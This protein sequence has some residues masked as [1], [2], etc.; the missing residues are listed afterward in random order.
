VKPLTGAPSRRAQST[1]SNVIPLR[2]CETD[3][4]GCPAVKLCLPSG[5]AADELRTFA[6]QID[7]RRHL[8]DGE[9]LYRAG[10]PFQALYAVHKGSIKTSLLSEDGR[11]Q[12]AGYYLQGEIV[13]FD[14]IASASHTCRASALEDAK[15]CAIPFDRLE[16]LARAIPALQLGIY[17]MLAREVR[18]NHD[19]MLLFGIRDAQVRLVSLLLEL[20]ER[21]RGRGVFGSELALHLSRAE[22]GSYLGLSLAT[23]SRALSR[24]HAAGLMQVQ[25]RRIKLL[26]PP[27]LKRLVGGDNPISPA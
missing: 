12:V 4:P 8:Q 27:S 22:M 5:L 6:Q 15:V 24:L 9:V 16:E 10:D 2:R 23:V 11:E 21:Y 25:G 3:C 19:L 20:S 18:R 26:D 14:G 13:G 17:R 1:T 7:G